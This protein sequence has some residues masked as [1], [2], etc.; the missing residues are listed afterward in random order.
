MATY[1][2]AT[3]DTTLKHNTTKQN[4]TYMYDWNATDN[5]KTMLLVL[6]FFIKASK[7]FFAFEYRE[8]I[9]SL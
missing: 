7:L 6:L 2:T 9:Y 4:I 5:I 8:E 3:T 1:K